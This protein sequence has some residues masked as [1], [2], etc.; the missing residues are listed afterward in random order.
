MKARKMIVILSVFAMMT[1]MV[2]AGT[3]N[4]FANNDIREQKLEQIEMLVADLRLSEDQKD[5]FAEFKSSL[6]VKPVAKK[7]KNME[8]VNKLINVMSF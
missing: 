5:K 1:G 3:A 7:E 2:L 4:L 6:K 8:F